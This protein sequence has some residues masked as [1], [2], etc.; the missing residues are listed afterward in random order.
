MENLFLIA[1]AFV[2]ESGTPVVHAPMAGWLPMST[3]RLVSPT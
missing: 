3:V 2:P 1:A